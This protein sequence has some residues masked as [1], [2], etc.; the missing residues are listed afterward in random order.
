MPIGWIVVE[1]QR[2]P[3][4]M[5]TEAPASAAEQRMKASCSQRLWALMLCPRA[6][7]A[8]IPKHRENLAGQESSTVASTFCST[9]GGS[10]KQDVEDGRYL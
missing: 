6:I 1:H 5:P 8:S 7:P 9:G 3:S 2:P 10:V 4:E